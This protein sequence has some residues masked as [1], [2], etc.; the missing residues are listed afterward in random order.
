MPLSRSLSPALPPAKVPL[1]RALCSRLASNNLTGVADVPSSNCCEAQLR[2]GPTVGLDQR[3]YFDSAG[4][5][6]FSNKT[7][8]ADG[9]IGCDS[10]V[11][12]TMPVTE[13]ESFKLSFSVESSCEGSRKPRK[14]VLNVRSDAPWS[15]YLA[16]QCCSTS[17]SRQ[18]T[19]VLRQLGTFN[20]TIAALI[21]LSLKGLC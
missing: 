3:A 10:G 21:K 13:Y 4:S 12:G 7:V 1:S 14:P 18:F 17:C 19:P 16:L 15:M 5:H 6:Y 11:V 8:P 2:V 9:L 20:Q